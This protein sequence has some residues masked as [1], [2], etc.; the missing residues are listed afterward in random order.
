ML[1]HSCKFIKSQ[2]LYCELHLFSHYCEQMETPS[3]L[4]HHCYH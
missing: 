1:I 3:V 4:V 2:K